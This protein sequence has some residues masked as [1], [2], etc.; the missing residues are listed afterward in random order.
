VTG[1]FRG[2]QLIRRITASEIPP[3]SIAEPLRDSRPVS[4]PQLQLAQLHALA[5]EAANAMAQMREIAERMKFGRDVVSS[6]DESG[7][8]L[9]AAMLG[10][11]KGP[12]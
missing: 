5:D 4:D 3:E 1:A 8:A 11:A 6:I 7:R 9:A 2:R 10:I 12:L